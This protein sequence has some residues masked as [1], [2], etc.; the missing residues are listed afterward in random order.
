LQGS[1]FAHAWFKNDGIFFMRVEDF[2]TYFNQLVVCRPFPENHF[3]IEFSAVWRPTESFLPKK[4]L[5]NDRQY[6]L[7]YDNVQQP[8]KVTA[9]L[10]QDDPRLNQDLASEYKNHRTEMGLL[11]MNM[12]KGTVVQKNQRVTAY[13]ANRQIALQLPRPVRTTVVQF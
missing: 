8:V 11:I 4:S 5:M 9:I 3:G 7:T 13:D 1:R 6:V 2:L 10:T 12:G